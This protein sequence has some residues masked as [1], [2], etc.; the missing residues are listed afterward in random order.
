MQPSDLR[1]AIRAQAYLGIALGRNW[2]PEVSF[3]VQALGTLMSADASLIPT[4]GIPTT[5]H[6]IQGN[7]ERRDAVNSL[8]LAAALT[9]NALIMGSQGEQLIEQLYTLVNWGPEMTASALE[10]L[11]HYVRR[12]PLANAKAVADHMS[13]HDGTAMSKALDAAYRLRILLGNETFAVWA[14]KITVG[15]DLLTDMAATYSE[16]QETPPLHR[17]YNTVK[18]LS[19]N[20]N[21]AERARLASNFYR[22]AEQLL[23]LAR[24]RAHGSS[25]QNVAALLVQGTVAPASGVDALRW[26]G[27]YFANHQAIRPNLDRVEPPYLFG[28]RSVN[29]LLR[30]TDTTVDLCSDL[31][32]AFP[33]GAPPLDNAAFQAEAGSVWTSMPPELQRQTAPK[34]GENAQLLAELIGIIGDKGTDR[35]LASSGYG[36]QL[37]SGRVQP[38]SV[39][40]VMRW[41]NGYFLGQHVG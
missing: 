31:L 39:I 1:S 36:R 6:V 41:V 17:L 38:Q 19:G 14:D 24:V 23:Q 21:D 7:V 20:L 37:G 25:K 13:Q 8:K 3:A 35:S 2:A 27:G 28:T 16:T 29:T 9:E 22:L 15:T 18:A 12:A 5:L 4:I 30:D 34:L 32:A 26:L 40:D 11:R 10:I 33:E